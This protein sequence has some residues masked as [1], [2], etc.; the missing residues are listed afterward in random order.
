[1]RLYIYL[2]VVYFLSLCF[3]IA[4]EQDIQIYTVHLD[5]V[6]EYSALAEYKH[7]LKDSVLIFHEE[8]LKAA[9]KRFQDELLRFQQMVENGRVTREWVEKQGQEF[10]NQLEILQDKENQLKL[11]PSMIDSTYNDI[12]WSLVHEIYKERFAPDFCNCLLLDSS[13]DLII[14]NALQPAY[15]LTKDCIQFLKDTPWVL[16]RMEALYMNLLAKIENLLY[17]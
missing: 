13:N 17:P 2:A 14:Y 12:T 1:M 3:A 15:V 9:A 6:Q 7:V 8:E 16:E 10:T 4:Q 5:S 11:L